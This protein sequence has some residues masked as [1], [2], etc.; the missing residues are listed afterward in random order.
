ML[1]DVLAEQYAAGKSSN[2]Y[3]GFRCYATDVLMLFCYNKSLEATR[4]PDFHAHVVV[5][6]ET[7]L[8]VLS[9][10]KYSRFLVTLI[11]YFPTWLAKNL[12]SSVLSAF[13]DLREVRLLSFQYA[14]LVACDIIQVS[15][16]ADPLFC[17]HTASN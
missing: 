5:A 7:M 13:Y 12:G 9:L 6:S 2:L 17:I 4:A 10:A 14:A 3:L 11:H 8:P 15:S 1:C 16:G